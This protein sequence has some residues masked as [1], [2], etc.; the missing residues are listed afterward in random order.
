VSSPRV[1]TSA[2]LARIGSE[3]VIMNR[4]IFIHPSY[5]ILFVKKKIKCCFHSRCDA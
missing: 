3:L 1:P 4:D 2:A 5:G